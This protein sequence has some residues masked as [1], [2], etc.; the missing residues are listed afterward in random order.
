MFKIV[1]YI[2]CIVLCIA[3]VLFPFTFGIPLFFTMVFIM[4]LI[5]LYQFIKN[6]KCSFIYLLQIGL[7]W[8]L[9]TILT[10]E[11]MRINEVVY[12]SGGEAI[13]NYNIY[14]AFYLGYL[15]ILFSEYVVYKFYQNT[16]NNPKK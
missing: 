12:V 15:M 14:I 2:K 11:L 3:L 13:L 1:F 8:F 16:I 9:Y 5:Y 7:G 4:P 6:W 10:G